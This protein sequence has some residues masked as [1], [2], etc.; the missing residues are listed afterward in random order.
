MRLACVSVPH[1]RIALERLRAPHLA[2]RPVAIGEPPPGANTIIDC[3]PEAEMLG[4]RTGMPPRDAR[5]VA[6]E[7]L[8]L[9]P[10]PV[11]YDRASEAMLRALEDCTPLVEPA[12]LGTAYTELLPDPLRDPSQPDAEAEREALQRLIDAVREGSGVP[13]SA[14]AASSKFVARVAASVSRPGEGLVVAPGEEEAFLAPLSTS[15]LPVSYE[16]QRKLALYALRT[17]GDI[18]RLPIGALQAQFGREGG[19]LWELARGI[20]SE[21]FLPRERSEPVAGTITMP[22]PTVN[23]A[24]LVIAARQLAGRLLARPRMRYRQVRQL[25]LRLALLGGGSWERT[26][27]FREPLADEEAIV[28]VLRKLIEPLQLAG[29]VEEVSLEFLGLTGETGKQRSLLFAEQAR[30][31]AQLLSA[32]RQLKARFGGESQVARVVEVEPWSRIPERRYALID[33]DL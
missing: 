27:T 33:Y 5:T 8:V 32:L 11:H 29:A 28:Y 7:L 30:R 15:H 19:R 18:A 16:T 26:L 13:A 23:S 21:P 17:V 24:A 9:P 6:P 1:V 22:A 12:G 25:R 31:R 4:V 10:D 20:D 2:G 14:G 3:S